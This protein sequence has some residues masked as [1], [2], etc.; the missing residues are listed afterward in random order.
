VLFLNGI[1]IFI[2]E[3]KSP[4]T[5]Q[6]VEDGIRQY[7]T[8]RD[9]REP[10]FAYARC[11]AHFAVDPDLVYV[12]THLAGQKTRFLPFNLG[13]RSRFHCRGAEAREWGGPN[14]HSAR[15]SP[16]ARP[17]AA[18]RSSGYGDPRPRTPH[19]P[20]PPIWRG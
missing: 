5:G 6:D 15:R 2:A 17:S 9:P 3:F 13:A 11:L 10:L 1:P 12:T 20:D 14:S 16:R 19:V 7:K 8:D 4:L 18:R